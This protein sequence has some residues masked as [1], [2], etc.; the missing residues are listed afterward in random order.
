MGV[1]EIHKIERLINLILLIRNQPGIKVKDLANIFETCKRTIYRDFNTLSLAGFPVYSAPGKD[2]GY[3]LTPDYFLPPLRFTCEE[4][5][6]LLISIKFFLKQKGFPYQEHIQLALAKL[7]GA[8]GSDS[9]D[10]IQK[11]DKQI[12]IYL[13]KLKDY[14]DYNDVFQKINQAILEKR[15]I[16]IKYYTITRDKLTD[17]KLDPLHLMFKGGFWYLIAFCHWREEIKIFRIDRI[18]EIT[19]TK[20]IFQTPTDFSLSSYLGKSWQVVRGEC[21]PQKIEIKIF[22]PASRWVREERRHP[23]QEIIPLNDEVILFKVEVDSFIEI[24]KWILQLG[25]CAQVL[26]P[27]SLREEIQEEIEGMR[28]RYK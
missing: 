14:Q 9:R 13:G 3:F 2:G 12:S 6:S 21:E 24:K 26:Q 28:E 16:Q 18:R 8:L 5:A 11:I 19:L 27:K 22:L 20:N 7:E 17:R 1:L 10:Y 4:A 15:Q 23:T 25:S